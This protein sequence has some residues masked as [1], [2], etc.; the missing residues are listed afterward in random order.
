MKWINSTG[1]PSIIIASPNIDKWSGIGIF[2]SVLNKKF[3]EA[4]DFMHPD[5]CLIMG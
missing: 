5:Q 4:S 3:K 2:D 1:G